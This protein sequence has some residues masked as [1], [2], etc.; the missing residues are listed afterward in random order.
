[1]PRNNAKDAAGKGRKAAKP[2]AVLPLISVPEA[3]P[4]VRL[5]TRIVLMEISCGTC[6]ATIRYAEPRAAEPPITT[7]PVREF[8]VSKYLCALSSHEA[9]LADSET[10]PLRRSSCASA[11]L[12]TLGGSAEA[13]KPVRRKVRRPIFAPRE[14]PEL[15]G[16]SARDSAEFL[17]PGF[18][19]RL[20]EQRAVPAGIGNLGMNALADSLLAIERA[21]KPIAVAASALPG[22]IGLE[23][24]VEDVLPSGEG[25]KVPK[26]VAWASGVPKDLPIVEEKV[27]AEE[28]ALGRV[29]PGRAV[30][31]ATFEE[32]FLERLERVHEGIIH[33][34]KRPSHAFR[35]AMSF[36]ALAGLMV[37]APVGAVGL[38]TKGTEVKDAVLSRSAEGFAS[39]V[40]AAGSTQGHDLK[41]AAAGFG[42]A[43]I[44][45]SEARQDISG[46]AGALKTIA[47][48]LPVV[49]DQVRGADGLLAA[50]DSLSR[51]G[52][53][54]ANGIDSAGSD[55]GILASLSELSAAAARAMPDVNDAD[56]A[57]AKVDPTALPDQYQE[58]VRSL[59]QSVSL[60]K[61]GLE[62]L[63]QRLDALSQAIGRD[64][65]KRYLVVFQ[66]SDELRA[67]GGFAGSIAEV[68]FDK[69]A[70]V[71]V[72]V[73]EGGSYD[74]QGGLTASIVPPSPL[75]LV[76]GRWQFHDA[77][78]FPDF[79]TTARKWNW[80]YQKSGGPSVDGVIAITSDILP[81]LLKLTG[82]ISMP[83]YR[84]TMTADNVVEETERVVELEHAPGDPAPKKLIGD[85]L[86]EVLRRLEALPPDK[87]LAAGEVL[88]RSFAA[89]TVQVAFFDDGLE[90]TI[91]DLGWSGALG[92]TDGDSLLV[93]D[94]N[95]GGGKTDGVVAKAASL[96]AK[97]AAD[98]S[99]YDTLTLSYEHRGVPTDKLTGT[100]YR[101]F[102]R[103][104]VPDGS[105]LVS[106]TGDFDPPAESEYDPSDP[107]FT[108]DPDLAATIDKATAG[109]GGT[110]VWQED[111]RTVFG[112]WVTI[113]PGEKAT[114]H[115]VYASGAK[116][117]SDRSLAA[118]VSGAELVSYRL[119]VGK[120][121]GAVRDLSVVVDQPEG[122]SAA[123]R[124]PDMASE[125]ASSTPLVSDRFYGVLYRA[126]GH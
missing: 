126:N 86:G 53:T 73:P 47:S 34:L 82:P 1:M 32:P 35:T 122:Y 103:V 95:V 76:T 93:V 60:A 5:M 112:N 118:Q 14:L 66:N 41:A 4:V 45:F 71:S 100:T 48:A 77:N 16:M 11:H 109:P 63:P 3:D 57:L 119:S 54:L 115:F 40:S 81:E 121:A 52:E 56:D 21:A 70:L 18:E 8:D 101:D 39:L 68:T 69:G 98:G 2:S 102:V 114:L 13:A 110:L 36:A 78:W 25:A 31:P 30:A 46:A 29:P 17:L 123:W 108:E 96:E 26:S 106:A 89:K 90:S 62:G 104:Y 55:S 75:R 99:A 84:R 83:E 72:V 6:G 124:S 91:S 38:V 15:K 33:A 43:K 92:Q 88:G 120:Q 125:G 24:R 111:G 59:K 42:D 61:T 9:G 50:A 58:P 67:T 74:M 113:K 117:G 80:F 7:V 44:S 87:L 27:E 85:L 107:S 12:L 10:V 28:P 23:S 22:A 19:G 97:V 116:G 94:T 65:R 20:A 37:V 51:A 105:S 49:G 64:S 79:P